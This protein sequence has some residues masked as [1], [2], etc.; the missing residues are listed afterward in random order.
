MV[1]VT[2]LPVLLKKEK[3]R[4]SS[5]RGQ[6]SLLGIDALKPDWENKVKILK[7]VEAGTSSLSLSEVKTVMNSLFPIEQ[8]QF[9]EKNAEKH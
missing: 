7:K 4:D 6:L 1:D 8:Q 2:E 9:R 5:R 3:S